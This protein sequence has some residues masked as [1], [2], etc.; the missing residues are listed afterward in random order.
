MEFYGRC[1]AK[2]RAQSADLAMAATATEPM[3]ADMRRE[4]A[5]AELNPRSAFEIA[6]MMAGASVDDTQ[7]GRASTD[8]ARRVGLEQDEIIKG[9]P[10]SKMS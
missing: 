5:L 9:G 2:F 1:A 3:A 7:V 4:L 6:G 8:A 10:R